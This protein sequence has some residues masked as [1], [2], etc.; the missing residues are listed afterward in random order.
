MAAAA[1][2]GPATPCRNISSAGAGRTA[3]RRRGRGR[4]R[5]ARGADTLLGAWARTASSPRGDG[6]DRIEDFAPGYDRLVLTGFAATAT[7]IQAGAVSQ[8]GGTRID[9]GGGD[10]LFLAGVAKASL[11]AADFV[12]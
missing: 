4:D 5:G 11:S 9:L 10:G 2:A 3:G 8:G 6:F 12:L 7:A 1:W